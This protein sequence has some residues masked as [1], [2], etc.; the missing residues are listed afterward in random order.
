MSLYNEQDL[1]MDECGDVREVSGV[2]HKI[3]GLNKCRMSFTKGGWWEEPDY[4]REERNNS[5]WNMSNLRW[6]GHSQEEM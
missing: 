1:V 3:S 5:S 4:N 6:L 2:T